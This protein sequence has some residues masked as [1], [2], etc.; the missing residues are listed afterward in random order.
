MVLYRRVFQKGGIYFFTVTLRN[1]KSELLTK[2]VELLRQSFFETY[3]KH[4]FK[5][6]SIVI[7]PDHIHCIWEL[8]ENDAEYSKR[9]LLIKS[10][11]S[12][13]LHNKCQKIKANRGGE[14]NIWA[15]RFW[16]H[17][18]RDEYDLEK[19]INYI[20]YNPVK[21]GFVDKPSSWKWSSIHRYIKEGLLPESWGSGGF[22]ED[23]RWDFGE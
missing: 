6:I 18:I 5:I 4:P 7:M 12:R 15:R 2:H 3:T 14:Y 13:K 10:K 20:H 1:R 16:E 9:W 22:T 17:L 19:H 23:H 11:F 8:P 21:H